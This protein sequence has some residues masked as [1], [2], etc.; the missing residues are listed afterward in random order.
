MILSVFIKMIRN[1][2]KYRFSVFF[3]NF[4]ICYNIFLTFL[5][6]YILKKITTFAAMIW[7]AYRLTVI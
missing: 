7:L 5:I 1:L 4:N 6:R 2:L 3:L